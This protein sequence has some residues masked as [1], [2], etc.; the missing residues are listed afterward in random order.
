MLLEPILVRFALTERTCT[1]LSGEY[2][3]VVVAVVETVFVTVADDVKTVF[4]LVVTVVVLAGRC[5]SE[6]T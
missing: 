2:V 6:L 3:E 5:W 1:I 4:T